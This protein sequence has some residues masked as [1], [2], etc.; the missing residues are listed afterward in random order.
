MTA[1]MTPPCTRVHRARRSG[2]GGAPRMRPS[3]TD[4]SGGGPQ[5]LRA[6][7]G[8]SEESL[9]AAL[10]Q[11]QANKDAVAAYELVYA[12]LGAK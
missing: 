5:K 11:A 9:S 2:G 7:D 6:Q 10:R 12:A 3:S 8:V 4:V 1:R